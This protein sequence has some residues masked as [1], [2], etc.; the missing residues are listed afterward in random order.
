MGIVLHKYYVNYLVVHFLKISFP[1]IL[2]TFHHNVTD[3][4]SAHHRTLK[5]RQPYEISGSVAGIMYVY[6]ELVV[7]ARWH[8][9]YN[10]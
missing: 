3:D 10:G 5:Q 7:W 9:P 8:F 6:R 4:H 2:Q 1:E